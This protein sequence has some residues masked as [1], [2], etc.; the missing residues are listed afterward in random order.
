MERL[1]TRNLKPQSPFAFSRSKRIRS[2]G[3]AATESRL[4]RAFVAGANE[5]AQCRLNS[6]SFWSL[7]NYQNLHKDHSMKRLALTFAFFLGFAS[8]GV[9]WAAAQ[10]QATANSER[11]PLERAKPGYLVPQS[12]VPA[13]PP[14]LAQPPGYM[15]KASSPS[16]TTNP[17]SQAG[18]K[19]AAVNPP[20]RQ[21]VAGMKGTAKE[22]E[23]MKI[24]RVYHG[25]GYFDLALAEKL[26][27][28]LAKAY[29]ATPAS[30]LKPGDNRSAPDLLRSIFGQD[31][32][33]ARNTDQTTVAKAGQ[34]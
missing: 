7:G 22:L 18:A 30:N 13:Q 6:G 2:D 33:S 8:F 17:R 3:F 21:T 16:A 4:R 19:T 24:V 15:P 1:V 32:G 20:A 9:R 29:G 11:T 26:Q 14:A 5:F 25:E 23:Q 28:L 27:P 10:E 34:P 31:Q 12:L